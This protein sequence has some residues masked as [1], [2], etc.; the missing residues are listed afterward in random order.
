M[1]AMTWT[2]T[3]VEK[4]KRLPLKNN[5]IMYSTKIPPVSAIKHIEIVSDTLFKY[6]H[7]TFDKI[8]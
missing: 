8:G 3:D 5:L 4:I 7:K 1:F 6:K 2:M